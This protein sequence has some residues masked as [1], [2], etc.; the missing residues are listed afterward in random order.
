MTNLKRSYK[1]DGAKLFLIVAGG[2]T[3]AAVTNSSLGASKWVLGKLFG[4]WD[5][6][7]QNHH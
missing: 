4:V 2:I 5:L 6:A 1:D 7:R 3:R